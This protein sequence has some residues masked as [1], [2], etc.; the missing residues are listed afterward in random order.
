[1]LKPAL[2]LLALAALAGCAPTDKQPGQVGPLSEKTYDFMMG[3]ATRY[4]ALPS[5]KVMVG[6]FEPPTADRQFY[7]PLQ[8]FMWYTGVN[9]D[10]PVFAGTMMSRARGDCAKWRENR[11]ANCKCLP[12]DSNDQNLLRLD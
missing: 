8:A 10:G 7:N 9:S 12:V 5:P 11:G 6:C 1:M 2:G 3:T 4:G